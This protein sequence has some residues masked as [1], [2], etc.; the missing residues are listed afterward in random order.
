MYYGE[1]SS[2]SGK[3]QGDL[4]VAKLRS[5]QGAIGHST[6]SLTMGHSCLEVVIV[7]SC[8]QKVVGEGGG[9]WARSISSESPIQIEVP[10]KGSWASLGLGCSRFGLS[11]AEY[12]SG[13]LCRLKFGELGQGLGLKVLD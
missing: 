6:C 7:Y 5:E 12:G 1:P 2:T 3:D 11:V 8:G 10:I 13:L 4:V 9:H